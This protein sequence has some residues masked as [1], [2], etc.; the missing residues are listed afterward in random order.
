VTSAIDSKVTIQAFLTVVKGGWKPKP[1]EAY[2]AI[3]ERA[4]VEVSPSPSQKRQCFEAILEVMRFEPCASYNIHE[5]YAYWCALP[6][7]HERRSL[8]TLAAALVKTK[9]TLKALSP[10]WQQA[11]LAETADKAIINDDGKISRPDAV[12]RFN[13]FYEATRLVWNR[14]L[15]Y[16][17]LKPSDFQDSES[18]VPVFEIAKLNPKK[19]YAANCAYHL[20]IRFAN[21]PPTLSPDGA[22]FTL[23]SVLYE[24]FTGMPDQNVEWQ[25]RAVY[26]WRQRRRSSVDGSGQVPPDASVT[27]QGIFRIPNHSAEKR[28]HPPIEDDTWFKRFSGARMSSVL[29]A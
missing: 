5:H 13:E 6:D 8:T 23:A 19:R 22:F 20:L 18:P 17:D 14:T 11:L 21:K 12:K 1:S 9:N 27:L 28:R 29:P 26:R 25:C 7:K 2:L 3:A 15:M 24:S 16:L 4:M 10:Q